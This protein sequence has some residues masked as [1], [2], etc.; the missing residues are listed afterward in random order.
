[1]SR[2]E[3]LYFREC[4]IFSAVQSS[5]QHVNHVVSPQLAIS[6]EPYLNVSCEHLQQFCP[7]LYRQL[8]QYP[9]EVIPTFD[10]CIN[11][12]FQERFSDV[13][14]QHQ[15]Q[16][17]CFVLQLC[18]QV[19]GVSICYTCTQAFTVVLNG[20]EEDSI[21]FNGEIKAGFRVEKQ[22]CTC[23]RVLSCSSIM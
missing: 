4:Y 20:H 3:T 14:L 5:H 19:E 16:V 11:E 7:E 2:T 12:L 9:Q 21:S 23:S 10:Q 17:L 6:E 8:V 15:I 18:N 1:M 13:T 22:E